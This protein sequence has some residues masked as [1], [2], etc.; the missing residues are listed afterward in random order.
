M[1][2]P[3]NFLVAPSGNPTTP[4]APTAE[5]RIAELEAK[6][7]AVSGLA[8]RGE[9]ALAADRAQLDA[10]VARLSQA[11][12]EAVSRLSEADRAAVV[13][14][15]LA[16]SWK[17]PAPIGGGPPPPAPGRVDIERLIHEP[18]GLERA[19]RDHAEQWNQYCREKSGGASSTSYSAYYS[20]PTSSALEKAVAASSR[21]HRR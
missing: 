19:K 21:G 11:D 16:A 2:D 3:N 10:R 20:R 14:R 5:Q 9:Q 4:A 12:R 17:A 8:A 18:G 7:A 6:L 15:L 1:T 13:D